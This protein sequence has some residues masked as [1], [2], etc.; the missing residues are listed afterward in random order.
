MTLPTF[1]F[2]VLLS[3]L[4]GAAFHL[5]RGGS[6][7]RLLLY[8]LLGWAGFWIGQIAATHLEWTF[9]SLGPL[10]VGMASL[11]SFIFLGLGYWLSL[12]EVDRENQE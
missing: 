1:L 10:H 12:F 4:Y 7:G 9:L 5:W 6:A 8:L 3:T 11:T 2:G